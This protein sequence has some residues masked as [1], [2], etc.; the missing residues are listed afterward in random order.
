MKKIHSHHDIADLIIDR[1]NAYYDDTP[2]TK[3]C[4]EG[5][6]ELSPIILTMPNCALGVKLTWGNNSG[7]DALI[8]SLADTQGDTAI[9]WD[10]IYTLTQRILTVT[11]D[12][13]HG[14][15]RACANTHELRANLI[16]DMQQAFA[17]AGLELAAC[18]EGN[19]AFVSMVYVFGG[20]REDTQKSRKKAAKRLAKAVAALLINDVRDLNS[21]LT[22]FIAARNDVR[23][24]VR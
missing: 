4:A 23:L 22:L 24:R 18:E 11:D 21:T 20:K 3:L 19:E 14:L 17:D 9:S 12:T 13:G 8:V 2:V 10:H 6:P 15:L 1:A 16:Y 5:N 7:R